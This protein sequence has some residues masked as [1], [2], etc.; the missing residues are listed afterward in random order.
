MNHIN[1]TRLQINKNGAGNIPTSVSLGEININ[2]LEFLGLATG[3]ITLGV[4]GMLRAEGLPEASTNLVSALAGL[5]ADDFPHVGDVC[6]KKKKKKKKYEIRKIFRVFCRYLSRFE[7][8][9]TS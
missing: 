5:D 7:L 2:S 9:K 4:D 3:V 8:T 6:V 1:H